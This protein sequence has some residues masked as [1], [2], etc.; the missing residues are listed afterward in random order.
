MKQC[1]VCKKEFIRQ[2]GLSDVQ[3]TKRKY[4]SPKCAIKTFTKIRL[5]Q[6]KD[7]KYRKMM[8]EAHIKN[9]NG[10]YS[11]IHK[12]AKRIMGDPDKCEE[13]GK[14]KTTKKSIQWAN[15]NHKYNK[16]KREWKK[17]CASCHKNHD[18][19]LK[20]CKKL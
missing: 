11:T 15:I 2:S 9:G 1:L 19:K 20:R 17:L 12:W 16:V 3:W 18:L 10:W 8:S 7:Q 14:L 5:E 13:C 4:C 6:W